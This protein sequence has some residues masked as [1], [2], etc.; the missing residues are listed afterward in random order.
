MAEWALTV[1]DSVAHE[2]LLAQAQCQQGRSIMVLLWSWQNILPPL[3][4][5]L[6]LV[7]PR[8]RLIFIESLSTSLRCGSDGL[9]LLC[10]FRKSILSLD[11]S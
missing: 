4:Q 7:L 10:C 9:V 6:L 1:V 3:L 5:R 8:R 2:N 11:P